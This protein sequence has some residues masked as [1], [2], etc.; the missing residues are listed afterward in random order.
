MFLLFGEI[1]DKESPTTT[2]NKETQVPA[3]V[4]VLKIRDVTDV[5][6]LSKKQ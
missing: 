3:V 4:A 2:H 5:K 6:L 1:L